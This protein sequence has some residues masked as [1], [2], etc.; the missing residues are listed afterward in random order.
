MLRNHKITTETSSFRYE[1]KSC[2]TRSVITCPFENLKNQFSRHERTLR[3]IGLVR[4][5]FIMRAISCFEWVSG[6]NR[7]SLLHLF[8]LQLN[9][10]SKRVPIL[11][12]DLHQNVKLKTR[13]CPMNHKSILWNHGIVPTDYQCFAG[14][15]VK[16]NELGRQTKQRSTMMDCGMSTA[17]LGGGLD[18]RMWHIW[19]PRH[20]GIPGTFV[21]RINTSSETCRRYYYH[22]V[23]LGWCYHS[24][25]LDQGP[26]TIQQNEYDKRSMR[27]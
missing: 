22:C 11:D 3:Y 16:C 8:P 15:R 23:S 21:D 26:T 25:S 24:C 27:H 1:G 12:G 2:D 13:F 14:T 18:R 5:P 19:N 9:S 6:G 10:G 4:V 7:T 20:P 17:A